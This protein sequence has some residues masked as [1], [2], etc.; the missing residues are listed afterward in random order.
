MAVIFAITVVAPGTTGTTNISSSSLTLLLQLVMPGSTKE[1][2]HF[3]D[4]TSSKCHFAV[5]FAVPELLI[6][7]QDKAFFETLYNR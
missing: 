7:F 3:E 1:M 6:Y 4:E 2:D 5:S